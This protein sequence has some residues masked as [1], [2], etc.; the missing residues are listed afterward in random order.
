MLTYRSRDRLAIGLIFVAGLLAFALAPG[1]HA[2]MPQPGSSI[3]GP[4]IHAHE[5]PQV[6]PPPAL[7]GATGAD[8]IAPSNPAID[9]EDPTKVL[10]SAINHGN[11][12]EAQAAV[13]RGANLQARNSLD[14][15]PVE[16]SVELGRNNITFMLLSVM[17]EGGGVQDLSAAQPVAEMAPAGGKTRRPS[18]P[19]SG[20]AATAA[21]AAPHVAVIPP[22]AS[23]PPGLAAPQQGFLGFGNQ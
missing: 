17:R 1:A 23:N 11:Y 8:E 15:T 21:T 9:N 13:S 6:I 10:F 22:S 4:R 14:E 3:P 12:S 5:E 7:P 18:S 19:T 2:Q 16:L 20:L